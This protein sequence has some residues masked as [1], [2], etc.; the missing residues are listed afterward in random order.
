MD[1]SFDF[2]SLTDEFRDEA[3]E[4][5]AALDRALLRIEGAGSLPAADGS[6]LLRALHTLKGNAGMLG[7]EPI[8]E[9]VHALESEFR[10]ERES[11]SQAELDSFF[12]AAAV[13]RR[14][15][16]RIGEEGE[17]DAL[18]RLRAWRPPA[19]AGADDATRADDEPGPAEAGEA[20]ARELGAVDASEL[21]EEIRT[22]TEVLRV[23]FAA[24][25]LLLQ[26]VGELVTLGA[27]LERVTA[28]IAPLVPDRAE[29]RALEDATQ[30]FDRLTGLLRETTMELRL[31]PVG[32]VLDRFPRVARDLAREQGKRVHVEVEGGG[33]ELDKSAVDALAEP[34]LHLV[35]NAVDHGIETPAER[36]ASGRDATGTVWLRAERA[37]DRLRIV[38]EDDGRGLDR[39]AI[40][41]RARAAG[42]VEADEEPAPEEV[43]GLIFRPGFSTRREATTVSGRG[44]G[45]DVVRR[46]VRE[47]RGALRVEMP[48]H[49]GTRFTL[50]LPLTLAIVSA[51]LFESGGETMAVAAADVSEVMR[52]PATE[53]AGA[54]EVL[55]HREHLVPVARPARLFGWE[56]DERA[57]AFAVVVGRG[58]RRAAVLAERMVDQRDVVVKPLPTTAGAPRGVSGA[59]ITPDGRVVLLL[60]AVGLVD[61]NLETNRKE[62]RGG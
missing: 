30:R 3:R 18:E 10:G 44:V 60:D 46:R 1:E 15:V 38:V 62:N 29:V 55:R 50:E 49:G 17:E 45:L 20:T 37:G 28:A 56:G 48:E 40:L 59:T 52:S 6:E 57:G 34:L 25:D 11:W 27:K 13:L 21:G 24:L 51:V 58:T 43:R 35:R 53:R 22:A 8:V 41:A 12:E 26:R 47:L 14:A 9:V 23:P 39:G 16:E 36:E 33:V 7:L 19:D 32:R 54:V 61:L 42:L 5:L 4:Q 2:S 31:V